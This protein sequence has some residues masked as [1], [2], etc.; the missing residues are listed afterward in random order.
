MSVALLSQAKKSEFSIA[1]LQHCWWQCPEWALWGLFL[2]L[3][4]NS[5]VQHCST[6]L[7]NLIVTLLCQAPVLMV[8]MFRRNDSGRQAPLQ[9]AS[10]ST[11]QT[12]WK[13]EGA[14][15]KPSKEIW[16][17]YCSAKLLHYWWQ[18]PELGECQRHC[19]KQVFRPIRDLEQTT[20]KHTD[21][22]ILTCRS[23]ANFDKN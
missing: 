3:V 1:K 23:S 5:R 12:H 9:E 6:K 17:W 18:C 11:N 4:K 14:T 13:Y 20:G 8:T 16:L 15:A 22:H 7:K 21:T 19:Q 2:F 10:S